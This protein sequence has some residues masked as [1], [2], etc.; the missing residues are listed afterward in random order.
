MPAFSVL[1]IRGLFSEHA[2]VC[3]LPRRLSMFLSPFIMA[4]T[5]CC[6]VPASPSQLCCA[7]QHSRACQPVRSPCLCTAAPASPGAHPAVLCAGFFNRRLRFAHQTPHR[8]ERPGA[9]PRWGLEDLVRLGRARGPAGVPRGGGA[10]VHEAQRRMS[11]LFRKSNAASSSPAPTVRT[12][13]TRWAAAGGGCGH[14]H[15]L[16][17]ALALAVKLPGC[18]HSH[19]L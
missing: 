7:C 6:A 1:P 4:S 10:S 19:L 5:V 11:F 13:S 3:G 17:W 2:S 8:A 12:A 14:S 15:S 18:G 16:R 9:A